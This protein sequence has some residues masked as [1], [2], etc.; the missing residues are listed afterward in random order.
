MR[1]QFTAGMYTWPDAV[2]EVWKIRIRGRYPSCTA[3]VVSE[4]APEIS[5][6]EAMTVAAVAISTR[7]HM[8]QSGAM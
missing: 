8:A 5:A 6:C 3:W 1:T 7:G 2:A 4:N